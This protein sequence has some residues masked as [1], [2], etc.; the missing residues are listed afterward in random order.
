MKRKIAKIQRN[1]IYLETGETIDINRDIKAKYELRMGEVISQENYKK[2]IYESALSKSFYLLSMRDY[3]ASELLR[4]LKEKYKIS[5]EIEKIL[6]EVIK[7]ISDLGY[8]DDYEYAL[9]YINRKKDLGLKRI[10]Y[11]LGMKGI[12]NSIIEDVYN[13]SLEET[14][15]IEKIEKLIYKIEKKDRNKQIAYF[16]R[17]GFEIG[18][19]LEVLENLE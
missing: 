7:K 8:L 13:K 18:D 4:K 10:R 17:R 2:I 5:F 16:L 14:S 11:E 9:S 1:K 19:V 3:T 12:S 15:E 6:L